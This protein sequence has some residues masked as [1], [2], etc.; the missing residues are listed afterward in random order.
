METQLSMRKIIYWLLVTI[1]PLCGL[2]QELP[3][4]Q[5]TTINLTKRTSVGFNTSVSHFLWGERDDGMF[6]PWFGIELNHML[7][8]SLAAE[9][10]AALGYFRPRD[11][12]LSG[13]NSYLNPNPGSPYRTYL[14]PILFNLK[15]FLLR[16]TP[17][18]PYIQVGSGVVAWET[19]NV[20][21][22]TIVSGTHTTPTA[23]FGFGSEFFLSRNV[24]FDVSFRYH[25]LFQQEYD[26]SGLGDAN[27]GNIETRSGINWYFGGTI[28]TDNDG[29]PDKKD[30]YPAEPEDK[31]GFEDNDGCPELDNDQ[32]GIKDEFDECPGQP[33]D[34]DGYQDADGCQDT[35]NDGD[36]V[37]D[38]KDLCPDTSEDMDGFEDNDGCPDTD[39]DRDGVPDSTDRCLDKAEDLDGYRDQDG[40]PDLD[41][42]N[43]G[44]PD[45]KDSCPDKPETANGY[46][47]HDGCPD[48][49]PEP[50]E[51][52]KIKKEEPVILSGGHFE[53]DSARLKANSE[54]ILDLVEETLRSHPEMTVRI[55]GYTDNIGSERYNN[56]LSERRAISVKQ[57]LTENGIQRSR[58][59]AEGRGEANPIADN[60]TP[61]GREKNR[62]IEIIRTDSGSDETTSNVVN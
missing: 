8:P 53:F 20:I 52:I 33:E 41:N 10:Y 18:N 39:N 26:M 31:D 54:T 12:S 24:S 45:V 43:D 19:R 4:M 29:V 49:E 14:A 51:T 1:M 44:I 11:T 30:P 27:T 42:D 58:I 40:C 6:S 59:E 56:W 9:L 47:D 57:Y 15:F 62:R 22:N 2:S 5:Q 13:F 46:Q 61:Y 38:S 21:S 7:T 48:K 17:V 28:D 23:N 34:F 55:V 36:K 16:G 37:P 25:K 50:R 3:E 35:D 32:D 60:S